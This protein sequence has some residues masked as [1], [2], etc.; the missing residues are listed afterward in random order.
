MRS[1]LLTSTSFLYERC[2]CGVALR[3][4]GE[5]SA[6]AYAVV[7]TLSLLS[8]V[9]AAGGRSSAGYSRL[10]MTPLQ[11]GEDEKRKARSFLAPCENRFT[12]R[13]SPCTEPPRRS[14]RFLL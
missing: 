3:E 2:L 6:V 7:L 4:A 9:S 5:M 8:V 1:N 11:P 14:S 12:A 10:G 13:R